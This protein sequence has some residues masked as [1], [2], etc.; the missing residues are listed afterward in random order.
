MCEARVIVKKDEEETT[1]MEDAAAL[2]IE[3]GRIVIRNIMGERV[4]VE[5]RIE[6]VDLQPHPV[7]VEEGA[8]KGDDRYA[9]F[10]EIERFDYGGEHIHASTIH[11][12]RRYFKEKR[13]GPTE[14]GVPSGPD[15]CS[16][17]YGKSDLTSARFVRYILYASGRK[18]LGRSSAAHAEPA[19]RGPGA[20]HP[21]RITIK[22]NLMHCYQE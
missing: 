16:Q 10:R 17:A 11:V 8:L 1:V 4:E 19:V 18:R 20:A 21:L 2:L 5:G 15:G 7:V 9:V 14:N 12:R 3:D 22:E 13:A 6:R